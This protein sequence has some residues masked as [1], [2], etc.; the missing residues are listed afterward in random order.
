MVQNHATVH[1]LLPFAK[2]NA[3][4][5]SMESAFLLQTLPFP[6]VLKVVYTNTIDFKEA[7]RWKS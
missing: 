3:K 1:Q 7:Q 6:F 5:L 2:F 4:A